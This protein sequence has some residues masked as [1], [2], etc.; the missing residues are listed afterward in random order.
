MPRLIQDAALI[1]FGVGEAKAEV[2]GPALEPAKRCRVPE[3]CFE[4]R[5]IRGSDVQRPPAVVFA[6][7]GSGHQ[8]QDVVNSLSLLPFLPNDRRLT[9]NAPEAGKRPK[10]DPV[11]S[12]RR[13]HSPPGFSCQRGQPDLGAV[14]RSDRSHDQLF[15]LGV[16]GQSP[17]DRIIRRYAEFGVN[18]LERERWARWTGDRVRAQNNLSAQR[19]GRSR[20]RHVGRAQCSSCSA[21]QRS[22]S[23]A[24]WQPMPAAV[25]AWR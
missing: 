21:S 5:F 25:M 17:G 20:S 7:S 1:S 4:Q 13:L 2:T 24:A 6:V 22:A 10:H 3:S 15:R 19:T 23:M 14:V 8:A 16:K 18:S 9:L 12:C 11:M